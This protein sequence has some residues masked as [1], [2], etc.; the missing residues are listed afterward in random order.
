MEKLF[1]INGLRRGC[2]A[3]DFAAAGC[4]AQKRQVRFTP[5]VRGAPNCTYSL[6]GKSGGSS[7]K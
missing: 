3:P 2:G 1:F 6:L 5:A 4:T 7:P